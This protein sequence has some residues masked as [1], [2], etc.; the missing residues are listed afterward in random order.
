MEFLFFHLHFRCGTDTNDS[1]TAGKFCKSLLQFFFI[2]LACRLFKLC[3]DLR[4]SAADF[5]GCSCAIDNNGI[6]FCDFHLFGSAELVN[7]RI[8]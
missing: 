3:F 8:F 6:I 1:H 4:Y 7:L 2:I 5:F